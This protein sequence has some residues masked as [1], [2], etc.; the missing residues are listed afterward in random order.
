MSGDIIAKVRVSKTG[1]KTV[2]VPKEA[3]VENGDYVII[4]KLEQNG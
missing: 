3:P 2:T 1:Q 4:K